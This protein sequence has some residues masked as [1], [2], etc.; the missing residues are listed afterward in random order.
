MQ[1]KKKLFLR[2]EF[3]SEETKQLKSKPVSRGLEIKE[4]LG[5]IHSQ[6]L[7]GVTTRSLTIQIQE[8]LDSGGSQH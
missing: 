6:G 5:S 7:K 4:A 8:S 3:G 1:Y 2:M